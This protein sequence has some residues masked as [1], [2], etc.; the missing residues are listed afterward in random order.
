[1]FTRI[2]I[3]PDGNMHKRKRKKKKKNSANYKRDRSNLH[4]AS[5]SKGK[6]FF[7]SLL[8]SSNI[9]TQPRPLSFFF[10]VVIVLYLTLFSIL[11]VQYE[12]AEGLNDLLW[13]CNLALIL[14]ATGMIFQNTLFIGISM[15]CVAFSHI[16][17]SYD[18]VF[19]TLF[20]QFPMGRATFLEEPEFQDLW[21]TTLHQV[22]YL[23]L[24][25]TILYI[26]YEHEGIQLVYWIHTTIINFAMGAIGRISHFRMHDNKIVY[27]HLSTGH[28]FWKE[29]DTLIHR[30]DSSSWLVYLVW[31]FLLES[32]FLNGICF[33][34][35]KLFSQLLLERTPPLLLRV[36]KSDKQH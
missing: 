11:R 5:K 30:Y 23:P 35:L 14:G 17:F 24:C 3:E 34:F 19:W 31:I 25:F 13:I 15:A 18:L 33:I 7:A 21:W 16:S 20:D 27:H 4:D 22:W 2:A 29:T 12:G 9:P 36:Q 6:E 28:E 26:D 10:G 1:M 8:G 32:L